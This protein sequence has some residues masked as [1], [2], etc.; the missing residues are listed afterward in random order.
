MPKIPQV[1]VSSPGTGKT[2]VLKTDSVNA[3]GPKI[4][5]LSFFDSLPALLTTEEAALFLKCSVRTL[6]DWRYRPHGRKTGRI[7]VNLFLE[8]NG[9]LFI[10]TAELKRWF[11]SQ[12]PSLIREGEKG[13]QRYGT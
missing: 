3:A 2:S 11:V 10:N 12:N 5:A 1:R 9:R 6:Y 8:L 4:P 7:P 13:D